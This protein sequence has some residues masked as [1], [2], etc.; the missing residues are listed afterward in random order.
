MGDL[1]RQQLRT[2]HTWV[3][4][5][6]SVAALAFSGYNFSQLQ[7]TPQTDLALP[8]TLKLD[9]DES[10]TSVMLQPTVSTRYDTSDVEMITDVRLE[11]K[12]EAGTGTA[13]DFYWRENVKWSV[14]PSE[15]NQG[16]GSVWW[17]FASDPVPFN[18][19]QTTPQQQIL[20]FKTHN[21]N[22]TPGR[23]TGTLTLLRASTRDPIVRP[24]C[25]ALRS[26]DIK[27]IL[28]EPGSYFEFRRDV[29]GKHAGGCYHRY[30]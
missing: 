12:P 2:G 22:L 8:V 9:R 20:Q 10:G 27:T 4:S 29:P 13:P 25:L 14:I 15:P 1:V 18:V 17:E 6:A 7:E 23:Y 24:F 11:L 16:G 28:N 5:I 21:W 26:E 30:G 19:T 3:A